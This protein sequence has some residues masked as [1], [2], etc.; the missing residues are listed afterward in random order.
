ML[1]SVMRVYHYTGIHHKE[2]IVQLFEF[3]DLPRAKV[4][5]SPTA[6]TGHTGKG[7]TSGTAIV[8]TSTT[9]F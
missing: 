3:A 7:T 2:N 8:T 4:E 6:S 9:K 5:S 1:S